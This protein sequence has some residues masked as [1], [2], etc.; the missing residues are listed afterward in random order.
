[1]SHLAGMQTLPLPLRSTF[2]ASAIRI[3]VKL[4]FKANDECPFILIST[5]SKY[6][7]ISVLLTPLFL[8]VQY[9]KF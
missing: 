4:L 2:V 5:S 6:K 9:L 1:M 8:K 7:G 3:E